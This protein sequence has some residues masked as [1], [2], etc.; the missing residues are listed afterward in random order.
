ME[1]GFPSRKNCTLDRRWNFTD[2]IKTY[3]FFRVNDLEEVNKYP[4]YYKGTD[5]TS[6]YY[7][8][9]VLWKMECRNRDTF[10]SFAKNMMNFF[11]IVAFH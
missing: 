4:G 2:S 3:D 1:L 5:L 7:R 8:N 10:E 11:T 6:L 9:L